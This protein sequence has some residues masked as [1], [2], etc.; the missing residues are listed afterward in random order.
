MSELTTVLQ[1]R[2][3][4]H[5]L[6]YSVCKMP[7]AH[8]SARTVIDKAYRNRFVTYSPDSDWEH[9]RKL[10]FAGLVTQNGLNKDGLLYFYYVTE[11]GVRHLKG[12]RE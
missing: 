12:V 8:W 5:A 4:L 9:L 1:R 2:N 11:E 7:P 3:M 10:G 6:G